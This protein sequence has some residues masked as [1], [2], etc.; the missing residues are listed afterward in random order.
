MMTHNILNI[1]MSMDTDKHNEQIIWELGELV[2]ETHPPM[3]IT[4][5]LEPTEVGTSEWQGHDMTRKLK[6]TGARIAT[7]NTQR[8]LFAEQANWE[9]IN[10]LMQ[11]KR[12]DVMVITEPGKADEMRIAALKNWATQKVMAAEVVNR[13]NTSIGGGIVVLSTQEWAGVNRK[14]RVFEPKKADRDRAFAV[15]FD[16]N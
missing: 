12:I 14:V 7:L 13:S 4:D 2:E 10:E 3:E 1:N 5:M 6:S 11:E 15:E 9:V 8:K 16:I